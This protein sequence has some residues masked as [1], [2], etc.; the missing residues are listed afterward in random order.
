MLGYL[1]LYVANWVLFG[2][3][4]FVFIRSFYPLEWGYVLFLAGAF[5]FASMLGI[6]ALFAPSGLGVREGVLALFLRR[7]MPESVALVVSVASRVWVT[8]VELASVGVVYVLL[9]RGGTDMT[10][11]VDSPGSVASLGGGAEGE[12]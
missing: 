7:I 12:A 2:V 11:V 5:S 9:R 8:L 1:A 10:R 3:A 4:L 6:L